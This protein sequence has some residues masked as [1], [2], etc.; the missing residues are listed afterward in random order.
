LLFSKFDLG[1]LYKKENKFFSII[2][3]INRSQNLNI[4]KQKFKNAKFEALKSKIP[5]SSRIRTSLTPQYQ[6]KNHFKTPVS[7]YSPNQQKIQ[8]NSP[9]ALDQPTTIKTT[10]KA[11]I[12]LKFISARRQR[13]LAKVRKIM[14]L[15]SQTH[16]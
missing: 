2:I 4:F 3:S 7:T 16:L 9:C 11:N 15:K 12:H 10:N 1:V 5:E 6:L 14:N 8:N 13:N